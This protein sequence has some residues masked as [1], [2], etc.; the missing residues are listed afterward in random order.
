MYREPE[1]SW[2]YLLAENNP[3]IWD[4][5]RGVLQTA[6]R[7][8]LQREEAD[9]ARRLA[10]RLV[11]LTFSSTGSETPEDQQEWLNRLSRSS[12]LQ[13]ELNEKIDIV[14]RSLR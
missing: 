13:K 6:I 12:R 4:E 3:E 9:R 1:H 11:M 7:Y 10:Q 5:D 8:Y 2:R 14:L